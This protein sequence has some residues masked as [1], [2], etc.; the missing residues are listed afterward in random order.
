MMVPTELAAPISQRIVYRALAFRL[1]RPLSLRANR[2]RSPAVHQTA[3][4]GYHQRCHRRRQAAGSARRCGSRRE[5]VPGARATRWRPRASLRRPSS[6]CRRGGRALAQT[7]IA[8]RPQNGARPQLR[9]R[10][11]R[12]TVSNCDA[13]PVLPRGW[14]GVAQPPLGVREGRRAAPPRASRGEWCA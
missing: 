4:T 1:R 8:G 5:P 13:A 2:S 7:R 6:G 11:S 10:G 14:D 3:A 12:A 9:L